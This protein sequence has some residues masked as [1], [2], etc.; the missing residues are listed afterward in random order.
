MSWQQLLT[1]WSDSLALSVAIWAALLMLALYVAR[2]PAHQAIRAA[3]AMLHQAFRLAASSVLR[4]QRRLHERNREVLLAQAQEHEERLL[5]REFHRV[6]AVVARDLSGYPALHRTLSDQITRIDEDYRQSTEVPPTPPAW[7]DAV[8]AIAKVPSNGDPMV[9][10]I[11]GDIHK[12]VEKSSDEAVREYRAASHRRHTFLKRMLPYWRNLTHTLDDVL[13]TITGLEERAQVID[14]HMARYEDIRA[15]RN[16]V[17]DSLSSSSMTQFLIAGLIM[18]IAGMGGWINFYLISLPM[19]EMVGGNLYIGG[20][21]V[22]EVAAGVI[23]MLETASGIFLMES[24]RI[25]RMFPV[26]GALDDKMRRRMIWITGIFLVALACIESSLAMLRDMLAADREALTQ[27]L[28]A[29]ASAAPQTAQ[30]RI[31]PLLAQMGMGFLLP[32]I[33]SFVAIP[34][35]SFIQSGRTVMGVVV[36]GLL[37]FTAFLLRLLGNIFAT[38]GSVLVRLYDLVVFLPLGIERLVRQARTQGFPG[39]STGNSKS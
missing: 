23:I 11:L 31:I 4:G 20:V 27:M 30:V 26:I 34:L 37:R 21:Q 36:E 6:N 16:S 9:A 1:L 2:Q 25:T 19:S 14:T 10:K 12:T 39:H 8:K 29:G 5:E 7:I 3:A 13:K 15:G 38:L 32:F 28:A 17:V 22:S 18:L 33:L 24:L 35:E